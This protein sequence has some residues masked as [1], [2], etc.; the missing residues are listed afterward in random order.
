MHW[1]GGYR[2]RRIGFEVLPN[3]RAS[4]NIHYPDPLSARPAP[5]VL[6]VGGHTRT[7][8]KNY[9]YNPQMWARRSYVCMI[10]DTIEQ[11]D[12]PGEHHDYALGQEDLWISLGYP[13]A[14]PRLRPP[15]SSKKSAVVRRNECCDHTYVLRTSVG[16][17]ALQPPIC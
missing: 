17:A 5:G 1:R 14:C 2:M 9:Q 4:A 13:S 12:N 6:Y 16:N 7:G 11:G 3:C 8:V 10:L 15:R